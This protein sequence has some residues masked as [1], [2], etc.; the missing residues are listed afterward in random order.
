MAQPCAIQAPQTETSATRFRSIISVRLWMCN[1]RSTKCVSRLSLY[2]HLCSV[3][4]MVYQTCQQLF[5]IR[6]P[7]G[8]IIL[9]CP[10]GGERN[11]FWRIGNENAAGLQPTWGT[12]HSF[13]CQ[14]TTVLFED[15]I[16]F[17]QAIPQIPEHWCS[18]DVLISQQ[19]LAHRLYPF[20]LFSPV[21]L[22]AIHSHSQGR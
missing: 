13:C 15:Q 7:I 18:T 8:G 22:S 5:L 19:L 2:K 17:Y 12:L 16:H 3:D 21:M 14:I 11:C 6:D 20:C 9:N 4:E 1:I 10:Q